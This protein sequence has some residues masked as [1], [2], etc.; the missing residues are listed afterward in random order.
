M[1]MLFW[2]PLFGPLI[3]LATVS[4]ILLLDRYLIRVPNP[5]AIS[6]LAVAFSAYLGGIASGLAAAGISIAYAVIYFSDPG[7]PLS[8]SP[9]NLA[10]MLVLCGATPA[11]AVMVGTLQARNRRALQHE[12]AM[13]KEL[14]A[15]RSALDQYEVGVVLL[16]SELRGQFINRAYRSLWRVSDEFAASKPSFVALLQHARDV[17]LYALPAEQIDAYISDRTALVKGGD[18]HPVTSGWPMAKRSASGARRSPT[19]AGC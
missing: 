1:R 12:Q 4:G 13:N 19:E 10:R 15:L 6:F 5:G 2:R 16:D 17:G 9:D 14:I 11:L 18:E 7:S 3:T 8:F